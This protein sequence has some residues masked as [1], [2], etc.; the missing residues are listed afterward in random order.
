MR[1]WVALSIWVALGLAVGLRRAAPPWERLLAVMFWPFFLMVDSAT[2]QPASDPLSRLRRAMGP[3]D[4]GSPLIQRLERA[5]AAHTSRVAR[6]ELE[7]AGLLSQRGGELALIEARARSL[8]TIELAL[9]RE[10]ES[11]A[12]A[13]AR[14]E[15]SATRLLLVHEE[16]RL[17]AVRP[18]MDELVGL[19]EARAEVER[20]G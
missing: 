11:W 17:A 13:Q 6:L 7:V 18:L 4:Q 9:R 1:A 20:T 10:R 2:P 12:G 8:E 5:L 15:E 3:D 16:G 19:L 14:I